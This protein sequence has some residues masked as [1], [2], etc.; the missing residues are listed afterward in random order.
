MRRR[1]GVPASAIVIAV[2][3]LGGSVLA[4]A[5]TMNAL[6]P[7][8][9]GMTEAQVADSVRGQ[10]AHTVE[11]GSTKYVFYGYIATFIDMYRERVTYYF[12][13]FENG[14]VVRRGMLT[15]AVARQVRALDPTF[16]LP[17]R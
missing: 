14:R 5:R 8:R 6:D 11:R 2:L 16:D 4:C 15:A 17:P 9:V 10:V 7:V 1:F 13:H 3:A 12:V